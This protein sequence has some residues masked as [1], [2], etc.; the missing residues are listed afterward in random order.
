VGGAGFRNRRATD[1]VIAGVREAERRALSSDPPV[2]VP[3][4]AANISWASVLVTGPVITDPVP[5]D[6]GDPDVPGY[7]EQDHY[8]GLLTYR[9][10]TSTSA[11]D[12]WYEDVEI[13]CLVIP[14][15]E[16]EVLAENKRYA[17]F[18]AGSRNG[19]PLVVAVAAA[20]GQGGGQGACGP[21][22]GWVARLK[23]AT[24]CITVSVVSGVSPQT[25][26]LQHT[27]NGLWSSSPAVFVYPSGSGV[28]TF[29]GSNGD[30]RMPALAID[31]K[32]LFWDCCGDGTAQFSGGALSGHAAPAGAPCAG[33]L[34]TVKAQC[35]DCNCPINGWAG[36]GWYCVEYAAGPPRV[37]VA[38]ELL[39]ADRCNP[40]IIIC[41][42]PYATRAD[43]EADCCLWGGVG[44]Y[45]VDNGSGV[46][47]ATYL[48]ITAR[49][50]PAV[51]PTICSG[52]Y[53]SEAAATAACGTIGE[54]CGTGSTASFT[55]A[56]LGTNPD[57]VGDP[58]FCDCSVM[59]RAWSL[60][61]DSTVGINKI[62]KQTVSVSSNCYGNG[63][64]VATLTCSFDIDHPEMNGVNLTFDFGADR[65][66][67]YI[68][69]LDGWKCPGVNAMTK[70]PGASYPECTNWPSTILVTMS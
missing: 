5:P 3:R 46:C 47:V 1:R 17:G 70:D 21:G 32:K 18:V 11:A 35:V 59:N 58:W 67:S 38:T 33:D 48:D 69:P 45:C 30:P 61:Y 51:I 16:G 57:F 6:S 28:V 12:R 56:G 53:A 40:D 52:P 68:A 2:P 14:Y 54:C 55:T 60:P 7:T 27:G 42:G 49:C 37:C 34:F 9:D 26:K 36:P 19:K 64:I 63:V 22:C 20:G 65:T 66:A 29:W 24:D 23:T 62:W 50:D 39:D 31:G 10:D 43:A 25:L 15:N 13:P 8:P 44:W 41:S 4:P